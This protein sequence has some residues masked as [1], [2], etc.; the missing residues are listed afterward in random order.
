MRLFNF[1][2]KRVEHFDDEMTAN[3]LIED[4]KAVKLDVPQL[5]ESERQAEEVYN[6]Y[7]SKVD[8]IK[9]S[10][11]PLLQDEKV[12]KYELERAKKEYE[13]QSKQVK[14]ETA[15]G[16]AEGTEGARKRTAPASINVYQ[17]D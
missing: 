17:T 3:E 2:N 9:N 7:K 15:P 13:Q 4:G 1:Q 8:S 12:Q 11:N 5:E 10:E 16:R 14:E 6:T